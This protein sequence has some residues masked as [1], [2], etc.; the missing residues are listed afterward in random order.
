MREQPVVCFEVDEID[1]D[2][3]WRSVLV[4]GRYEEIEDEGLRREALHRLATDE[5]KQ[6]VP[7]ALEGVDHVV[8]FRIRMTACSGRFEQ[9]DA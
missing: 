3:S 9:R 6:V 2:S 4:E 8:I 5:K 7:P 1:S